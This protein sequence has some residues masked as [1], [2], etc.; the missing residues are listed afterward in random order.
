MLCPQS[1]S[2]LRILDFD[3]ENRPLTYMGMDFTSAEI[4]AL[5]WSWVGS[6]VVEALLLEPDGKYLDDSGVG[7]PPQIA[8]ARFAA[9]LHKAEMVTG[10][11]IRKHDLPILNSAMIE[12]DLPLLSPVLVQDTKCDMVRKKDLAASQEAL[13]SMFNVP[14]VKQ[15]MTQ[16]Q[17]REANR[18]TVGGAAET[19]RRVVGDVVQH[20]ALREEMLRRKLLKPPRMWR[21]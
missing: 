16:G 14:A 8:L 7:W 13:A 5:A 15:H 17:W 3:L 9:L 21:S 4:T 11:Y 12:Y 6:G 2:S 1:K 19:K 20:L 10:H 18:L